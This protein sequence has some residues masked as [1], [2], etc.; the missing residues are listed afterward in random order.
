MLTKEQEPTEPWGEPIE[1]LA[2]GPISRYL[3][4]VMWVVA[5]ASM[6]ISEA[7]VIHGLWFNPK[8]HFST[9]KLFFLPLYVLFP[10]LLGFAMR[11]GIR[12]MSNVGQISLAATTTLKTSLGFLLIFS[13]WAMLYMAEIA[14]G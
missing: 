14:F 10:C 5:L 8:L 1:P 7:F 6:C 13:Y 3:P 2:L 12:K 11:V 4:E 9:E